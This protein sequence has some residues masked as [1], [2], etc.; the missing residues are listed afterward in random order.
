[1]DIDSVVRA[2]VLGE[3]SI[4]LRMLR[5]ITI[6]S[7][8][9]ILLDFHRTQME[10]GGA[11]RPGVGGPTSPSLRRVKLR[12]YTSCAEWPWPAFQPWVPHTWSSWATIHA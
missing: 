4:L 10:V 1:M 12:C 7:L 11:D 9:F 6:A 2:L 8:Y 3:T 5:A